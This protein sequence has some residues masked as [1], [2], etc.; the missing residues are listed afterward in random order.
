MCNYRFFPKI[1]HIAM[2]R[3]MKFIVGTINPTPQI[4]NDLC[5]EQSIK[6]LYV[7]TKAL[8]YLQIHKCFIKASRTTLEK[9]SAKFK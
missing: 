6:T 9:I 7:M 8:T 3:K 5:N 1:I 4:G 2:L